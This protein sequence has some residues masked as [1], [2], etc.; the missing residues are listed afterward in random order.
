MSLHRIQFAV[1][2][3][4]WFSISWC[5]EASSSCF[6]YHHLFGSR[7]KEFKQMTNKFLRFE[8]ESNT[9]VELQL[10]FD[11]VS[12]TNE[13]CTKVGSI[14]KPRETKTTTTTTTTRQENV[15][16][17]SET[18][19]SDDDGGKRLKANYEMLL[20][21]RKKVSLTKMSE[22]SIWVTGESGSIYERFWNGVQWVIVPHDLPAVAGPAASVFF[23][24]HSILALSE[25]GLLYQ[26]KLNEHSQPSWVEFPVNLDSNQNAST[27]K[28]KSGV[29]SHNQERVYFCTKSGSLHEL[30]EVEPPSWI[31]HKKPPGANVA[32]IADA[33]TLKPDV[34]FTISS[35]GVL[36]E[37]DKSS[38]PPWKK[39]VWTDN[40]VQNTSLM[41]FTGCC[42][43]GLHGAYSMSL[44]LITK[45]G[46]LVERRLHQRKWKWISHGSP[47]KQLLTSI[48]H[49]PQESSTENSFSLFLITAS[50]SILEYQVTKNSGQSTWIDHVH[51]VD[52]KAA[53]G[54]TGLNYQVGRTI[55][56]LDDGRLAELH[57]SGIG[58]PNS[59]PS[60]PVNTRRRASR[61]H[62][63]SVLEAPESEGWNGEYCTD[64]RGPFNCI[65]GINDESNEL[66]SSTRSRRRKG[67]LQDNSYLIP[68]S[69]Q[70]S[71]EEYKFP[72][73]WV[74]TNFRLRMMHKGRSFFLVTGNGLTMEY[75]YSENSWLWLRHEHTTPIRGAVGTYN[76]SLFLVD[77]SGNLMIRERSSDE[78]GSLGWIN[79]SAMKK[80]KQIMGGS[81]WDG[82]PM[83]ITAEDSLFFVSKSGKLLQ[84]TVAHRTFKWKDCKSPANTKIA[85]IVDKEGLR[86]N[87]LFLVG[88]NGRLYQ[89]NKLT[90]IWHQHYQSQYLVLSRLPGTAMRPSMGS[91]KGSIFMISQEGGLVEYQWSTQDGWSWVEHGTPPGSLSFVAGPGPGFDGDQ[92]FLIGSD[93]K[94]YLRCLDEEEWKWK[95][96]GFPSIE[97]MAVQERNQMELNDE[98][99]GTY[100]DQKIAARSE[101]G[102]QI[103]L[104]LLNK[105]CDPRVAET[106]PIQFGEDSVIFELRDARLAEIR[107]TG[108][109]E[110]TWLR[111]IATPTSLCMANYW[112]SP[113]A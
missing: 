104:G 78:N 23:V 8:E 90:G 101:G 71:S 36:Y 34:V 46:T 3:S 105:N 63:W 67:Q 30:V 52:A 73:R 20:P 72:D 59:G 106:R 92:L 57:L 47:D 112:T 60:Q 32:V 6:P 109:S 68:G 79:S 108:G 61:K 85:S 12:C 5:C 99:D 74:N 38:K 44:F 45:A 93:G 58:G 35:A 19:A 102:E 55:Y 26:M 51:P 49:V 21:V 83:K 14:N 94:V 11:L 86:E 7:S 28:I 16:E 10:P 76:A 53:R 107:R 24:N 29:V 25:A 39:H 13:S 50:G 43:Q 87:I 81:P 41:P 2:F 56:P 48:I 111:T 77:M 84:F 18:V 42:V 37:H 64:E 82:K 33:T 27:I 9:W 113:A 110:W 96:Y 69:V 103:N 91:L 1:I 66:A 31:N 98:K 65:S 88:R 75:I 17:I 70:V 54:I 97:N 89:Y 95:D 40:S 100:F 4:I 22:L 80:G 62:V 15:G